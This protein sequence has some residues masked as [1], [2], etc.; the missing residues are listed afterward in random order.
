MASTAREVVQTISHLGVGHHHAASIQYAFGV[1]T[2]FVLEPKVLKTG[3]VPKP[4]ED[5]DQDYDHYDQQSV[6]E[7]GEALVHKYHHYLKNHL[8]PGAS[9]MVSLMDDRDNK[10]YTVDEEDLYQ[11]LVITY[12]REEVPRNKYCVE[13]ISPILEPSSFRQRIHIFWVFLPLNYK[14]THENLPTTTHVHFAT[15]NPEFTLHQL[16]LIAA[17]W[18]HW[19]PAWEGVLPWR[20]DHVSG[21]LSR[22]LY[23]ENKNFAP[24]RVPRV[25]AINKLKSCSTL[26]SFLDTIHPTGKKYWGINFWHCQE[27]DTQTVEFRRGDMSTSGDHANMW[28]AVAVSFMLAALACGSVEE[29]MKAKVT[30]PA[31]EQLMLG[32]RDHFHVEE[33]GRLFEGKRHKKTDRPLVADPPAQDWSRAELKNMKEMTE[34]DVGH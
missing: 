30:V 13:V 28:M 8:R 14:I 32:A 23:M 6:D 2:E 27:G 26:Q 18:I 25:E 9:Y 33:I 22:S 11:Y 3:P 17:A 4:P 12:L 1:E 21:W 10:R 5:Y 29:I 24:A 15:K 20:G 19:E 31:L 34:D 7:W 16:V